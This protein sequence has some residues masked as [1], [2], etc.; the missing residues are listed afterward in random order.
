M[1]RPPRLARSHLGDSECY[2]TSAIATK[3]KGASASAW[4]SRPQGRVALVRAA[5]RAARSQRALSHLTV[6]VPS[7][8]ASTGSAGAGRP[9]GSSR[10]LGHTNADR[11]RQA[12]YRK[13]ARR[14]RR[15]GPR[16]SNLGKDCSSA[17]TVPD[18][19]SDPTSAPPSA[20]IVAPAT[21]GPPSCRSYRSPQTG[22]PWR[23]RR[24]AQGSA[25][26]KS[27]HSPD[28]GR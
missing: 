8:S 23:A 13:R 24:W 19:E 26:P 28:T 12:R 7:D 1:R 27:G 25:G 21:V 4:A 17:I 9:S 11:S 18:L 3:R 15:H 20:P 6:T 16:R 22:R 10:H 2:S 5:E 14:A